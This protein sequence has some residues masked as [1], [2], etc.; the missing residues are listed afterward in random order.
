MIDIDKAS[1][2]LEI[3]FAVNAVFAFVYAQYSTNKDRVYKHLE[4]EARRCDVDTRVVKDKYLRMVAY[5]VYPNFKTL[6]VFYL[7]LGCVMSLS[8]IVTSLGLLVWASVSG[9][10][11]ISYETF[12]A[13]VFLF[14]VISPIIYYSFSLVSK[15][16]VRDIEKKIL[17]EHDINLVVLSARIE[18]VNS[19]SRR[20]LLEINLEVLKLKMNRRVRN[21]KTLFFERINPFYRYSSWRVDKIMRD[22]E[23]KYKKGP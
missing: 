22:L 2:L 19:L 1:S 20:R 11:K 9:V 5:A 17:T 7:L 23:M 3:M 14:I 18:S 16:V 4:T 21:T 10:A 6:N 8:G 13:I 12:Y 15:R